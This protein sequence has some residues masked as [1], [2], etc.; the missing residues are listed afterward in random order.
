MT[1]R[2]LWH[3]PN[4]VKVDVHGGTGEKLMRVTG[5]RGGLLERDSKSGFATRV[6]SSKR[7]MDPA[8]QPPTAATPPHL[9]LLQSHPSATTS[10]KHRRGDGRL[11]RLSVTSLPRSKFLRSQWCMCTGN[12]SAYSVS[13]PS[14]DVR[15]CPAIILKLSKRKLKEGRKMRWHKLHGGTDILSS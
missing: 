12:H 11:L 8:A 4:A 6:G 5:H 13:L 1:L 9:P 10:L 7:R 14:K 15:I 2:L 3:F